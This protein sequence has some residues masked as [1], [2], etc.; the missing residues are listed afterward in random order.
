VYGTT[1]TTDHTP[2]KEGDNGHTKT[3]EDVQ[4]IFIAKEN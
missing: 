2:L 4:H 3:I 1:I